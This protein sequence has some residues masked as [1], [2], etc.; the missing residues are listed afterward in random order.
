MIRHGRHWL[1][2]TVVV[3]SSTW[4]A[5][6]L[7]Q[8]DG[9]SSKAVTR[10][11]KGPAVAA[12]APGLMVRAALGGPQITQT[13]ADRDAPSRQQRVFIDIINALFIGLNQFVPLLPS[14]FQQIDG[15]PSG[16]GDLVITEI[17][18]D[19]TN[20]FIEIINPSSIRVELDNWA[21]C[22]VDGCTA[23]GELA[24]LVMERDD[25]QVFQLTG[26]FDGALANNVISLQVG[27]AV[28]DIG[29]YDFTGADGRDPFDRVA[30]RDYVQWGDFFSSFGLE[31]VAVAA[32]IWVINSSIESSLANNSFQ[33]QPDRVSIGGTA[34]DYVVV[35]F[36]QHSLGQLTP[37]GLQPDNT[38]GAAN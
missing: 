21:F 35:P 33:L 8:D 19:G 6:A 1:W 18:H 4:P 38:S 15:A 34:D 10:Y 26:Q 20:A 17:A 24:G 3:V 14:I 27:T 22:K 25:V 37:S 31:D 7:A 32:G 28:D 23:A 13:R 5:A 36:A 9:Q 12:R 29:L 2:V 16:V 11:A 30:L